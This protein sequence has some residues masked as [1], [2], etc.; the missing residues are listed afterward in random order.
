MIK[1]D[2]HKYVKI[3]HHGLAPMT[4]DA[5]KKMYHTGTVRDSLDGDGYSTID[6]LFSIAEAYLFMQVLPRP[7]LIDPYALRFEEFCCT[8]L[9]LPCTDFAGSRNLNF[10]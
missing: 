8:A 3:A 7:S 4:A 6:T 1:I 10:G 5:R 2:R 9:L